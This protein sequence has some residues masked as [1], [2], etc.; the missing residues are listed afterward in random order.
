MYSYQEGE[1]MAKKMGA[2]CYVETSSKLMHNVEEVIP[3]CIAQVMAKQYVVQQP[4]Q[5]CML[6]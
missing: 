6:Q 3:L 2:L 1:A 4:S 5:T